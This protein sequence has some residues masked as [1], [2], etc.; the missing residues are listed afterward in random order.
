MRL[1]PTIAF[2]PFPPL[3]PGH[4]T[5]QSTLKTG[6]QYSYTT[7]KGNVTEGKK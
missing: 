5:L 3:P 6:Y 4:F 2:N 7:K 1:P